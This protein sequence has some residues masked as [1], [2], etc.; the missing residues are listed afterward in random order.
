VQVAFASLAVAGK[1]AMRGVPPG[2]LALA[3]VA[4]GALFFAVLQRLRGGGKRPPAADLARIAGLA[5]LGMAANQLLFLHGLH[6]TTA[7]NA[8]LLIT[9]IP[10]FAVLIGLVAGRERPRPALFLGLLLALAGVAWLLDPRR[11]QVGRETAAGDLLV[12][13]NCLCYATYLVFARGVIERHGAGAIMSLGFAAATLLVLP[14]AAF[15]AAAGAPPAPPGT[16]WVVLYVVLVPTVFAYFMN[17]W[18][19]RHAETSTVAIYIY[20]QPVVAALLAV[21]I[22]GERLSER[23]VVAAALVFAGIGLVTLERRRGGGS[24]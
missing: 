23:V 11:F 24:R 14:F 19:I 8:T 10:V 5:V 3:R 16:G 4:G 12:V 2:T 18:T 7:I 15:E 20:V 21:A 17:A 9:T 22:L 13:A 6:R 1:V